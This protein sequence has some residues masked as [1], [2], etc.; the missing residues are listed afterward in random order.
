MAFEFDGAFGVL[1][2]VFGTDATITPASSASPATLA[3]IDETAGIA[4]RQKGAEVDTVVPAAVVRASVLAAAGLTRT[5]LRR[6]AL[7]MNGRTYRIESTMPKPTP[8]GESDG[9]IL[10][11][12]TEDA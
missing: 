4:I 2:T 11:I 6:A 5:D 12:L 8:S 9:E 10:L 7:A 3:V 1:H